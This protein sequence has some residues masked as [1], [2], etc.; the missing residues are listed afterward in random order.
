M[1]IYLAAAYG[2][3]EEML[4]VAKVVEA[5]GHTVTSRWIQGLHDTPPAGAEVDS[6]E[7]QRWCANDDLADIWMAD[8]IINFTGG[9]NKSRGGRHVEF[10]FGIALELRLLI[11]GECEN[12]F[13]HLEDVQR[14][15]TIEEA[16][17]ALAD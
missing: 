10:G 4:E 8:C 14:F 11:V 16:L 6:P 1:K 5:A 17:A 9:G 13:H 12:V 3:R 7:H 15:D 2:R